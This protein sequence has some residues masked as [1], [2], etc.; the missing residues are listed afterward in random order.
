MEQRSLLLVRRLDA[1]VLY[2]KRVF[3][4]RDL[5][6]DFARYVDGIQPLGRNGGH[7]PSHL[8]RLFPDAGVSQLSPQTLHGQA[9]GQSS[10][11]MRQPHTEHLLELRV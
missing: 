2:V 10:A 8:S 4:G 5:R 3:F 7:T 11:P 1:M 9:C 6:A